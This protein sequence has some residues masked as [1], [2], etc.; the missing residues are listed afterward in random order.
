MSELVHERRNVADVAVHVLEYNGNIVVGKISGI[1]ARIS[2]RIS[3]TQVLIV[4][5]HVIIRFGQI[6]FH[7]NVNAL[8]VFFVIRFVEEIFNYA[9]RSVE[10]FVFVF[11]CR[12]KFCF[13]ILKR[14]IKL[15]RNVFQVSFHIPMKRLSFFRRISSS[16]RFVSVF[17]IIIITF[18]FRDN[19]VIFRKIDKQISR[20]VGIF[21]H[22]SVVRST[23]YT[24]ADFIIFV[25][26]IGYVVLCLSI[27]FIDGIMHFYY[28]IYFRLR[29]GKKDIKAASELSISPNH[30]SPEKQGYKDR[31]ALVPEE[32][33]MDLN[34]KVQALTRMIEKEYRDDA[35]SE[36]L[37]E[38]IDRFHHPDKYKTEEELA[39]D[40][41]SVIISRRPCALLKQVKH[42]PSLAVDQNKCIGCKSC[43][44]IGCPA[45]SI[46]EGKAR[47][48]F[49]QCVGCG[50]CEQLCGVNAF[51]ST[52]KEEV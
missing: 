21:L 29:D 28:L 24:R 46:V 25:C 12:H 16:V 36:W 43:M 31:V 5:V 32:E 48:D 10:Y 15:A 6:S 45:I 1:S 23:A 20:F 2:V 49:T 18:A 37:G 39:A 17:G 8:H 13:G 19:V 52:A 30:W 51:Y 11:A 27:I 3:R 34:H 41:P 50:V 9:R 47:V 40:E 4:A 44:R 22:L 7:R 26:K 42:K 33:K 38:V 35:D 14:M